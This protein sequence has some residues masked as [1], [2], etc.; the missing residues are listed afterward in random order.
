MKNL[1]KIFAVASLLM[2]SCSESFIELVP[3][4]T[5]TIDILYKTDKDYAD[6]LTGCYNTLQSIYGSYWRYSDLLSEDVEHQHSS[7]SSTKNFD[8]FTLTS[9]DSGIRTTWQNYYR[10]INR[11]NLV[12]DKIEG[13]DISIVVNKNRYI[14]EVKFLRALAYFNLVRIFGDVP[15]ITTVITDDEALKIG[16]EKVDKIYNEVIIKD[17]F[18]AESKLPVEYS[19]T[20]VGRVTQGAA[21]AMLGRVYLTIHDFTKAEAKLREVTTM[22]YALL[23][24]FKDLWDYTKNEHHSEYIFDI[25]FVS[26]AGRGSGYTNS[27]MPMDAETLAFYNIKGQGGN[28]YC[29][30]DELLFDLFVPG[31]IRKESSV[32]NGYT[33]DD[34]V[35]H[36]LPVIG[37]RRSYN[38]KYITPVAASGDSPANWKLIRYAD[39][40]LM[41]AEA[42]NE[43]DKT[44]EAL[45][46]LNQVRT[47]AGLEGYS[48]LTQTDLR[49][50]IYMERRLELC[51]EGHR[52]FDLLRTGRA[53]STMASYG[54]APHMILFPI[55]FTQIQIMNNLDIF[56]QNSGWD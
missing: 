46:Y 41:L 5:V 24:E 6:A 33:D 50:K 43:N 8:E 29:P 22:G 40:L 49:E 36:P 55:P 23:S 27:F 31:D 17:L 7:E 13:A 4:S 18:D 39:V 45:T 1:I 25:E 35:F 30:S 11:S 56:P 2:M 32:A 3:Q 52:W 47:R 51:F 54:M 14:G 37:H 12:L 19:G 34:G 21:K 38:K 9:D 28:T 16:R 48:G 53:Y 44:T 42:M 15:M 26:G 10:L 20:E